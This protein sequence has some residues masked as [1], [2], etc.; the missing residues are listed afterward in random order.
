LP[1][2]GTN[3]LNKYQSINR[4]WSSMGILVFVIS[5]FYYSTLDSELSWD[6]RVFISDSNLVDISHISDVF[7]IDYWGLVYSVK[8]NSDSANTVSYYRPIA[9][10]FLILERWAFG[11]SP[12]GFRTTHSLLHILN[13]ILIFF[14]LKKLFGS[15]NRETYLTGPVLSAAFFVFLPYTVDTVLFLTAIGDLMSMS[16]ILLGSISFLFWLDRPRIVWLA[17]VIVATLVAAFN[18][19]SAILFPLALTVI[20]FFFRIETFLNKRAVV[21]VCGSIFAVIFYLIVRLIV[22]DTHFTVSIWDMLSSLPTYFGNA[23]RY[24]IVPYP[25]VLEVFVLQQSF[26]IVWWFGLGSLFLTLVLFFTAIKCRPP[27]AAAIALWL[28][29]LIP[30]LLAVKA[31][32]FFATRYLYLPAIGLCI[33]VESIAVKAGF[34]LRRTLCVMAICLAL[35]SVDRS[36]TWQSSRTLWAVE[37]SRQPESTSALINL[38]SDLKRKGEYREAMAMFEKAAQIAERQELYCRAGTAYYGLAKIVREVFHDNNQALDLLK[39]SAEMC[40]YNAELWTETS[41][42]HAELGDFKKAEIAARLAQK[43]IPTCPDISALVAGSLAGQGKIEEALEELEKARRL[44]AKQPKRIAEIDRK[45]ELV[46]SLLS[47]ERRVSEEK[48]HG[49]GRQ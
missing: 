38:A 13:V 7:S 43:L 23:V 37:L 40:E 16:F 49:E 30:S 34:A 19:E 20:Y 4:E 31:T 6:D 11:K 15:D 5:L 28:I 25:L 48:N 27:I 22:I 46:R 47:N 14:F 18:K 35:A 33:V 21:A 9:L 45:T 1:N 36:V 24:A 3:K 2:F 32:G 8:V 26:D 12:R 42:I 29:F 10:A 17:G 41:S 39:K 44:A